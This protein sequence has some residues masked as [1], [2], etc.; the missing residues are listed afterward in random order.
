VQEM[1]EMFRAGTATRPSSRSATTTPTTRTSA[2]AGGSCGP[3][4]RRPATAAKA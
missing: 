1:Q 4:S 2:P 3:G